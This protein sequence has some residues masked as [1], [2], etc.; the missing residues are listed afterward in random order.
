[1]FFGDVV[2]SVQQGA[3]QSICC[4]CMCLCPYSMS[5]CLCL[6]SVCIAVPL[7]LVTIFLLWAWFYLFTLLIP[8]LN[9]LWKYIPKWLHWPV[10]SEN[11][12]PKTHREK[13]GVTE[14]MWD[15]ETKSQQHNGLRFVS[16][17]F[18]RTTTDSR[19]TSVQCTSSFPRR[20][21]AGSDL[22]CGASE[23]FVL[24]C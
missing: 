13:W 4:V 9:S 18:S 5:F 22:A 15:Y 16:S 23:M 12:S 1:M 3:R 17:R 20:W 2:L 6:G 7:Y 14:E 8:V 11:P 21:T 24:A 19:T 10:L